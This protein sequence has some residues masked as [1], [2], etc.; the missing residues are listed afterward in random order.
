MNKFAQAC[1]LSN[2]DWLNSLP[3][4]IPDYSFSQNHNNKMQKLISKMH[5]DKYHSASKKAFRIILV[6]A[7]ILSLSIAATTIGNPEREYYIQKFDDHS[8]Y[9]IKDYSGY[10]KITDFKVGYLPE[11]FI[12]IDKREDE[13]FYTYEYKNVNNSKITLNLSKNTLITQILFNTEFFDCEVIT[14]DGI[15]YATVI[16]DDGF[17]SMLWNDNEYIYELGG[18]ISLETAIKIAQNMK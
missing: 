6:A 16:E 3:D 5:G 18:N 15:D 7:V 1:V 9:G 8:I 12:L 14:V 13:D 11:D 4:D 2:E 17:I 10:K